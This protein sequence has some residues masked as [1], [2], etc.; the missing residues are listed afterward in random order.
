[1]NLA[2]KAWNIK[3]SGISQGL[4][5]I[6]TPNTT[7]YVPMANYINLRESVSKSKKWK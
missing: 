2:Y 5:G 3:C 4:V 6:A 1:M 7:D